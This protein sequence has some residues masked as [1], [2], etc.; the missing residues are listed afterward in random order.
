MKA[1]EFSLTLS[2]P[3]VGAGSVTIE[4]RNAG[5]DP[6]DLVVSTEGT[7]TEVARFE[8]L[9]AEGGTAGEGRVPVGRPLQ[10]LVL[11]GG[12]RAARDARH[13]HGPLTRSPD[14]RS[15]LAYPR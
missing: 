4:V 10:A 13:A 3:E 11:A 5:E 7:G 15:R 12:S 14:R 1:L 9:A 6:H 8:E 2:R